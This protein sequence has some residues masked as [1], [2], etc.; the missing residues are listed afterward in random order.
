MYWKNPPP[1]GGKNISGCNLGKK[2]E[3]GKRKV[4]KCKRKRK[5][6]E[7]KRKK[8]ERKL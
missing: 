1:P 3:K 2:Y 4:G 6:G 8:R 7:R 5:K